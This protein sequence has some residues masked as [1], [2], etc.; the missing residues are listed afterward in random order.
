[1]RDYRVLLPN[2]SGNCNGGRTPWNTWVSCEE[3]KGGQCW[4]VD[5]TGA[6]DAEPTVLGGDDGG[7]FE[8]FAYDDRDPNAPVFFVTEDDVNGAVRRFPYKAEFVA[9]R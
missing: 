6:Q 8:A 4:Q 7:F 5:P 9:K 3:V 1:M 2:S